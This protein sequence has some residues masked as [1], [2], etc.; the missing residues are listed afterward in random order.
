MAK[1]A[2]SLLDKD[3]ACLLGV[4]DDDPV[5]GSGDVRLQL[6]DELPQ[7]GGGVEDDRLAQLLPGDVALVVALQQDGADNEL[8]KL[9]AHAGPSGCGVVGTHAS[10]PAATPPT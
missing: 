7:V 9:D 2:I 4:G 5:V 10:V 6:G 8:E 3:T 1:R